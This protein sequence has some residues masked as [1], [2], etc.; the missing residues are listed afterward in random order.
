MPSPSSWRELLKELISHPAERDRIANAVG[1]RPV[2]LNRWISGDFKPRQRNIIPLLQAIPS[3]HR[4]QFTELLRQ[5]HL[6]SSV[7]AT[8]DAPSSNEIEL[9][10]IRQVFETR[11]TT[12]E[13]LLFWTLC[14]KVLQ[15]ALRL[16]D[17]E[18]VGM[19][20]TIALCMP[21]TNATS[22]GMIRSLREVMGLGTPPWQDDLEYQTLFLGAESLAGYVVS[23]GRPQTIDDL[24][25]QATFLPVYKV[26]YEVSAAA[27]PL[28]YANRVGGC[29]LFSSTQPGYFS[30]ASRMEVIADYA[31]LITLVLTPD[32]FYPLGCFNLRFMPPF[33][34]QQRRFRILQQDI[35]ALMKE[36]FAAQR[37]LSRVQAEQI[38]WQR[39]EEEFIHL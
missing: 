13:A 3:L 15:H 2:T 14:R 24:R 21:P 1:V 17:S 6:V 29:L 5:D 28:M 30:V 39:I 38:V 35:S 18:S 36:A 37:S 12:Q 33:E 23:N 19:A 34:V 9:S 20:I 26:E 32:Q 7:L 31:Q 8:P 11:A 25:E 4:E 10:F 22:D 16:L 27:H